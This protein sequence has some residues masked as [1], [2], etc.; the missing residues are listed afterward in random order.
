MMTT[1]PEE[2][3]MAAYRIGDVLE[4]LGSRDFV[5]RRSPS[6]DVTA[7]PRGNPTVEEWWTL[8][9]AAFFRAY[10]IRPT[11]IEPLIRI[12]R[13]YLRIAHHETAYYYSKMASDENEMTTDTLFVETAIY[14]YERWDILSRAAW[15]CAKT[16]LIKGRPER[17]LALLNEGQHALD[18][19]FER[20]GSELPHLSLNKKFY[21]EL[22]AQLD[23][24]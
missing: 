8:V 10:L 18:R 22:R 13:R 9:D 7:A 14:D 2:R 21:E 12:A 1:Y 3:F 17:A 20:Y 24:T 19:I 15:W 23:K 6:T 16:Q 4:R 11:R 5:P